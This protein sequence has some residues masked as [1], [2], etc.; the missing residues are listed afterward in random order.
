MDEEMFDSKKEANMTSRHLMSSISHI[1]SQEKNQVVKPTVSELL[2]LWP[3]RETSL[4]QGGG[5]EKNS[6]QRFLDIFGGFM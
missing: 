2:G 5:L 1:Q 3:E 4:E 6:S